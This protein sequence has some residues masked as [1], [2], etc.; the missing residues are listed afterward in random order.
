MDSFLSTSV[1]GG[2]SSNGTSNNGGTSINPLVP[3]ATASS[4]RSTNNSI[5]NSSI[6]ITSL[7]STSSLPSSSSTTASTQPTQPT[8]ATVTSYEV[9]ID[10]SK[11]T[12]CAP[13]WSIALNAASHIPLD[14]RGPVTITLDVSS[15]S[16][17]TLSSVSI[18]ITVAPDAMTESQLS[19]RPH[20]HQPTYHETRRN[21]IAR[22]SS[23]LTSAMINPADST[24]TSSSSAE[25]I[26]GQ[27]ATLERAMYYGAPSYEAY[28]DETTLIPR[29]VVLEAFRAR[30]VAL[31]RRAWQHQQQMLVQQQQQTQPSSTTNTSSS[32]VLSSSTTDTASTT[33]TTQVANIKSQIL[34]ALRGGAN[35]S[36]SSTS[37]S[38]SSGNTSSST[39]TTGTSNPSQ[40]LEEQ[41]RHNP[42]VRRQ[43]AARLWI[44]AHS[45]Y[46]QSAPGSCNV[47]TCEEF[48]RVWVH[49]KQCSNDSCHEK[50]CQSSKFCLAHYRR[51]QQNDPNGT[52]CDICVPARNVH[53]AEMQRRALA[54]GSNPSGSTESGNGIKRTADQ[55]D[56]DNT[57][58]TNDPNK[59]MRT[60]NTNASSNNGLQI[61]HT[62]TPVGSKSSSYILSVDVTV[63]GAVFKAGSDLQYIQPHRS[64]IAQCLR[65]IKPDMTRETWASISNDERQQLWMQAIMQAKREIWTN[66][67]SSMGI[68]IR[69]ASLAGVSDSSSSSNPGGAKRSTKGRLDGDSTLIAT[70]TRKQIMQHLTSL[71][72]DFNA[73]VTPDQIR[74][75]TT[76]LLDSLMS[77]EY[78]FIF[79][80]A[81][82]PLRQ[83]IPD[84]FD[85]IKKPMDFGTI[86][87][88]L[89]TG[90]YRTYKAFADDV[91]LVFTNALIY[92]SIDNDV[93]AVA[94]RMATFFEHYWIRWERSW[95]SQYHRM[96]ADVNNCSL[97]GGNEFMFEPQ[98]LYCNKCGSRVKKG[99]YYYTIRGN[100]YH[101]CTNCYNGFGRNQ[102]IIVDDHIFEH[103]QL[104]KKRNDSIDKE[105]F[106]KCDHC[107]RK[108]HWV[109]ALYNG[110]RNDGSSIAHYC[111]HC[112]LGH[113]TARKQ[114]SPIA[115]PIRLAA[116]LPSTRLSSH[117]ESRLRVMLEQRRELLA[118]E[119]GAT[120]AA[121]ASL[122]EVTVR[123]VSN[124]EKSALVGP[125]FYAR[126]R[127]HGCPSQLNYRS[128][129]L[130]LWQNLTGVDVLLY[131][132]YVQEYGDEC[133]EPSRRCVYLSYL[134]S[135]KYFEPSIM[136]TD[137]YKEILIAYLED[138][139]ARGFNQMTLWSC[140]PQ[141]GDDYIIYSH[142]EDQKTPKPEMLREWYL[143]LLEE[144]QRRG[145]VEKVVFLVDD[146]FPSLAGG[147][148]GADRPINQIPYFERDYVADQ[149]ETEAKKIREAGGDIKLAA[150]EATADALANAEGDDEGLD[151]DETTLSSASGGATGRGGRGGR[152]KLNKRGTRKRGRGGSIVGSGVGSTHGNTG[153]S[154]RVQTRGIDGNPLPEDRLR[155]KLGDSL[156]AMR[157]DFI[158]AKLRP[159][160][161]WCKRFLTGAP[162]LNK[163][164]HCLACEKDG[165]EVAQNSATAMAIAAAQAN[166]GRPSGNRRTGVT[167]TGKNGQV[168]IRV[169][170]DLCEGCYYRELH[171]H[172][173][174]LPGLLQHI[175]PLTEFK[176]FDVE[177]APMLKRNNDSNVS[178]SNTSSST[179]TI[180]TSITTVTDDDKMKVDTVVKTDDT[181][182][183][184]GNSSSTSTPSY[185]TN[186]TVPVEAAKP[187]VTN[188]GSVSGSTTAATATTTLSSSNTTS[189]E[190]DKSTTNS[191]SD[192]GSSSLSTTT[193][194]TTTDSSSKTDSVVTE[195][196]PVPQEPIDL[197]DFSAED[198]AKLG[199]KDNKFVSTLST[200]TNKSSDAMDT[201]TPSSSSSSI[202]SSTLLQ[203]FGS[204]TI[205]A[206]AHAPTLTDHGDGILE[207]PDPSIDSPFWKTRQAFLNLCQG[208]HYQFDQMRRA[209]HSSMMVLYHMHHPYAPSF[210]HSCNFCTQNITSGYRWSCN[211]CEDFDLCSNCK[212]QIDKQLK[213]EH[214]HFLYPYPTVGMGDETKQTEVEAKER[215]ARKQQE[216]YTGLLLHASYCEGSP[217]CTHPS[218]AKLRLL[219]DHQRACTIAR[220]TC[221]LCKRLVALEM[222]H[223]RTCKILNDACKVPFCTDYKERMRASNGSGSGLDARRR[224]KANALKV[225]KAPAGETDDRDNSTNNN[226]SNVSSSATTSMDVS[227]TMGLSATGSIHTTP[228]TAEVKLA[229]S[230]GA[231]FDTA[232]S[233]TESSATTGDN[234]LSNPGGVKANMTV[235]ERNAQLLS[236]EPRINEFLGRLTGNPQY[237]SIYDNVFKEIR[238]R[239]EEDVKK[240][241]GQ[242]SKDPNVINAPIEMDR[243]TD[244]LL[245]YRAVRHT[246]ERIQRLKVRQAQAAEQETTQLQ[247]AQMQALSGTMS[248][249][250]SSSSSANV[251]SSLDLQPPLLP[252][253]L[254]NTGTTDMNNVNVA[255]SSSS[256]SSSSTN[257]PMAPTDFSSAFE[258]DRPSPDMMS[259]NNNSNNNNG[260]D[261]VNMFTDDVNLSTSGNTNVDMDM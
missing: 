114:E 135:V 157:M 196:P 83:N 65:Q 53:R 224:A 93:H 170:Y 41:S 49:I 63:G 147:E 230:K 68:P 237:S 42:E 254:P 86:R 129:A 14:S 11:L 8:A 55:Q 104:M 241:R 97:C 82:D 182:T 172:Q 232:T 252:S 197:L 236:L 202:S 90:Q 187:I 54:S 138:I 194:L 158:V 145:I 85:V 102:D 235:E 206:E 1:V 48:K 59:R 154:R 29:I 153:S 152:G 233:G 12:A 214:E 108:Q 51:C 257:N 61:I 64:L 36:S 103:S 133:A 67:Q 176:P 30:R 111:P 109:C 118:A 125:E 174:G 200:A 77:Q 4:L 247:V 94:Q 131:V 87:K 13:Y 198:L 120:N 25:R 142:P 225:G 169:K 72:D 122:P 128:K 208:N 161:Q 130:V 201:S 217:L 92:N 150:E 69:S 123:L 183:S 162:G 203:S 74:Q 19:H 84:Y 27:A 212:D 119:Q 75:M 228:S 81:V 185:T 26:R 151:G 210:V 143:T 164:Y 221:N 211:T 137:V 100:K 110:K 259:S 243:I 107:E 117:I 6:S 34:A 222:K 239:Y 79:N 80:T 126:Y 2:G 227:A 56:T 246:Q 177:L 192:S 160:C 96:T 17:P 261:S 231:R 229:A 52:N 39:A 10:V 132:I 240:S 190:T 260:R 181:K 38:A 223:A 88:R 159:S 134:D 7:S 189:Q 167:A 115:K 116:S 258:N 163:K 32:T 168:P 15:I 139:K 188:E 155:V 99:S 248:P 144:A 193:T 175:H 112:I 173:Q 191:S 43:Q 47:P 23:L 50:H 245:K 106:V 136:R 251:N 140:P 255:S 73:T 35:P 95:Q 179:T 178:S 98:T 62:P 156:K 250:E 58:D 253:P 21:Q 113:M 220:G 101:W 205:P 195:K 76:I 215:T 3:S 20:W 24:V 204:L 146:Y 78:S 244:L 45:R 70:F 166:A 44:L 89:D 5:G 60:D 31:Y 219:L 28:L 216:I 256:A 16:V 199:S 180:I 121:D 171:A 18:N 213:P 105:G 148:G 66:H 46:C 141:K 218:C 184:N 57:T 40:S 238:T 91:R 249:M 242:N 186:A 127:D 37:A 9:P 207:D 22:I 149:C 71:R 209:K 234:S 33:S 165:G 226:G 124:Y